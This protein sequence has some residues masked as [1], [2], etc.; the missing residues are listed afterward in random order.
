MIEQATGPSRQYDV[1]EIEL[2]FNSFIELIWWRSLWIFL[3][4]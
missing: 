1:R 3:Q 2:N 4:L